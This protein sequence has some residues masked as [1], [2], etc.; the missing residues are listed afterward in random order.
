MKKFKEIPEKVV[1]QRLESL[2]CDVCGR[3]V[4]NEG[5]PMEFQ[6][7]LNI[8]FIG[9]YNS[10]FGDEDIF[11]SELCQHC[12]KKILGKYLRKVGSLDDHYEN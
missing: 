8:R 4:T 7:F 3:E 9:G 6:E 10:I 12:V 2:T 11:E 1:H 5:D